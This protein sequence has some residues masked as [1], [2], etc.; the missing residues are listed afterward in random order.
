MLFYSLSK[1]AIQLHFLLRSNWKIL[2]LADF[3]SEWAKMWEE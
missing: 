2:A 1:I 3:S